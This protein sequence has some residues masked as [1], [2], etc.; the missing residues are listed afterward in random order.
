MRTDQHI[1]LPPK[2][3][4]LLMPGANPLTARAWRDGQLIDAQLGTLWSVLGRPAVESG[5][6]DYIS[7]SVANALP[8]A[9]WQV[10][11]WVLHDNTSNEVILAGNGSG[12]ANNY[13]RVMILPGD[14]EQLQ[15]K[16]VNSAAAEENIIG[17]VL[18]NGVWRFFYA[19]LIVTGATVSWT[20]QVDETILTGSHANGYHADSNGTSLTR[21][22]ARANGTASWNGRLK[23]LCAWNRPLTVAER[24][25]LYSF[26]EMCGAAKYDAIRI[27]GWPLNENTGTTLTAFDGVTTATGTGIAWDDSDNGGNAWLCAAGAGDQ[28]TK[29]RLWLPGTAVDASARLMM[30]TADFGTL[31]IGEDVDFTAAV[32]VD[33]LPAEWL[34]DSAGGEYLLSLT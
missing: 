10:S 1:E 14:G 20:I 25:E 29:A 8:L 7:C 26:P 28:L 21:L 27:V 6:G 3:H 4:S 12:A 13:P 11:G 16:H 2:L 33:D 32:F 24:A 23:N 22:G 17:P 30:T 34:E 31:T 15:I 19:A 9:G 18:G 5:A